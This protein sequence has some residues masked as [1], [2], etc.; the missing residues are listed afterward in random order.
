[1]IAVRKT[2]D[3]GG[4]VVVDWVAWSRVRFHPGEVNASSLISR[5]GPHQ[6]D[7]V[8]ALSQENQ[9]SIQ[10]ALDR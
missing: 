8:I 2:V 5:V 4:G 10:F 1:M 9:Q 3:G 6:R 7:P